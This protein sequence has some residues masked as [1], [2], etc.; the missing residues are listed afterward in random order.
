MEESNSEAIKKAA[1]TVIQEGG[2]SVSADST[3]SSNTIVRMRQENRAIR[4]NIYSQSNNEMKDIIRNQEEKRVSFLK[5]IE[6]KYEQ[7]LKK[8]TE[9][10]NAQREL[11]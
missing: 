11:Q 4:D 3:T 2:M 6:A 7:K 10:L 8:T 5:S 9:L 1:A